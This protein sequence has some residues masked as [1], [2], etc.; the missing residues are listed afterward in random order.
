MSEE[1][2]TTDE[3]VVLKEDLE[4]LK[5]T[6]E[7]LYNFSLA[8]DLSNQYKNMSNRLI[9]SK[10]TKYAAAGVAKVD[11]YLTFKEDDDVQA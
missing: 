4:E 6:L 5:S 11:H 1:A 2:E 9:E 10:I 7:T 8:Q 3:I